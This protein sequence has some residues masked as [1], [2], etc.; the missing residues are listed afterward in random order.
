MDIRVYPTRAEMGRASAA[1]A[2]DKIREAIRR[3]GRVAIVFASAVSQNEFLAA[4]AEAPDIDWSRVTALHMD[5][6]VGIGADHPASFRRFQ[7][8]G[9]F[10]RVTPAVFHELQGDASDI[11]AEIQ[12]YTE[13]LERERP[14][15]CFAGIGENGHLAFNDPPVDFND[16]KL[17]R[18]VELDQTCRMQQVHDKQ[19]PSLDAVPRTALTLTV[20]ALTRIPSIVLNVPGRAKAEAV[21]QAVEGPVSPQCP[22]SILQGHTGATL[23]LDAESATLLSPKSQ[24]SR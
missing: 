22:A 1:L 14:S 8:N 5:E 19:F 17:V 13:I 20:P 2:A 21:R 24:K 18:V 3:D 23:F 11:N 15:L 6:Y 7:R 16:P 12:R 10:A 9:L 4:L